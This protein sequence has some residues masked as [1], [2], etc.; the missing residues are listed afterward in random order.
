MADAQQGLVGAEGGGGG[1]AWGTDEEHA[2]NQV[3]CGMDRGG[4]TM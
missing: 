1:Q 4:R 3:A 2:R